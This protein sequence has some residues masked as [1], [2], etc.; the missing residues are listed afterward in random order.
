MIERI[1]EESKYVANDVANEASKEIEK[2]GNE[3]D[4]KGEQWN[5]RNREDRT[6]EIQVEKSRERAGGE[7]Q[8]TDS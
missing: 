2:N 7:A 5:K 8:A 4:A 1:E 6:K 3:L